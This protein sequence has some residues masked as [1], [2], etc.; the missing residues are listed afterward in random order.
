MRESQRWMLVLIDFL[1]ALPPRLTGATACTSS[2]E[3]VLSVLVRLLSLF[4]DKR[5]EM[6]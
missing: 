2:S 3:Q 5:G 1:Q 6:T 4:N